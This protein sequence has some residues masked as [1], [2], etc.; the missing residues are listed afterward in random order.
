MLLLGLTRLESISTM[1]NNEYKAAIALQRVTFLPAS[2]DK[3]F[4]HQLTGWKDRDMTQKG[5]DTMLRLLW[6]Y[7][8]QIP[9]YLELSQAISQEQKPQQPHEE[10]I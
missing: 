5:R 7:R 9:K 4:A 1:T 2:F 10:T 8:R 3:R 6:K